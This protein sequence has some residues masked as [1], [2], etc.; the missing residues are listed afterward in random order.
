MLKTMRKNVKAL[1]PALW[2]VIAAFIISI[3][4][5]WGGAG[6][7]G[8]AEKA[9][10]I[11]E[12][13]REKIS[14]ESYFNALRGQ[15]ERLKSGSTAMTINRQ[16][17][18][19]L[20]IPQQVLEQ[21]IEQSLLFDLASEMGIRAS[22]EEVKSRIVGLPGL[23][24]DGAFIGYDEYKRVLSYNRISVGEFENSLRREVILGKIVQL[25]TAGV[26]S[27][28]DE[29]WESYV[30]TKDSAKIEFLALETAKVESKEKPAPAEVQAYFEARK[31]AYKI[32]EK[33]EALVVF[34]KNDDLKKEAEL[35]DS[36]LEKYYNANKAQFEMPEKVKVGRI[37]LPFAGKEKAQVE[38]EAQNVLERLRKG[39]DFAGLAKTFSKDDKANAGGDWGLY[40]WQTL[41]AKE[42]EEIRKLEAGRTSGAVAEDDGLAV[43]RVTEK[44]PAATTPLAEA[45]SQIRNILLDQRARELAAERIGKLEKEA[46]KAGGLE[47]AAK[48]VNLKTELTGLLKSGEAFGDADPSGAVSSALFALK[49]K[50]LS[51]PL[52]TFSGVGLA[53]L[54][55]IES[56]R[57][58]RFEEVK[59]DV[60]K[61]VE[62]S[63]KKDRALTTIKEVRSKLTDKNWED[64]AAKYKLEIKTVDEHK[65]EQYLSVIGE[66]RTVDDLAFSLPL[67]QVSEPIV[68]ETGY[69]LLRVLDRKVG[70]K[71]DFAKE[72]DAETAA[73]LDQKKNKFLQAYLARRRTEKG[74]KVNYEQF[75]QVSQ[76][77]LSRYDAE[78]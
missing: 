77:I 75:L 10:T 33:R 59:A 15:I 28:P 67:K 5:I 11:A 70:T 19:Q 8:E 47:A 2:F 48:A 20:N 65:R 43:L 23:Q 49:E 26:T 36:D 1:K 14:A 51:A 68:F 64:L 53:E 44:T 12:I 52:Y 39:E 9:R 63:K 27:A 6:R 40:D 22:D 58:A 38:A 30:K 35:S 73:F 21:M 69:A 57:P 31:D 71:E 17:I 34:L 46:K 13:G 54:R 62:E 25:L 32:P 18:E 45:K 7:L 4:V 66:N 50:D 61:D 37:W 76:D 74:V 3:F 60:E 29:V 72:K 41:P 55:K 42:Q 56:P 16:L 24:R 78:K